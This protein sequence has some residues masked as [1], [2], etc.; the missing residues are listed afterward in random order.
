MEGKIA[1]QRARLLARTGMNTM[2]FNSVK[3]LL[4]FY[5]S[6]LWDCRCPRRKSLVRWSGLLAQKFELNRW[7]KIMASYLII[8]FG[9][10][11]SFPPFGGLPW[12]RV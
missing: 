9:E 6:M 1:T 5:V 4:A 2:R 7:L 3:F 8:P 10:T 11:L 12:P